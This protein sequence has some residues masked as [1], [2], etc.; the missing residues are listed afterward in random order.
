VPV[1]AYGMTAE[2]AECVLASEDADLEDVGGVGGTLAGNALSLA[3]TRATLEHVLTD[4]AFERMLELA[5]RHERAVAG[6]IESSG[7]PWHVVR[8]GARAEYASGPSNCARAV[9]PPRPQTP[10][11]TPTCTCT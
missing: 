6:V 5:E 9:K 11:S 4:E 1:A 2:V 10:S 8:L 3:A 7:L